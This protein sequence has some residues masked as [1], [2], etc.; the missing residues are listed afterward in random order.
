MEEIPRISCAVAG[1][2]GPSRER[3]PKKSWKRVWLESIKR[4]LVAGT[5]SVLMEAAEWPGRRRAVL[6]KDTWG[7]ACSCNLTG[8]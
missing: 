1:G 7:G 2:E 8:I 5:R 4:A 3:Y 6:R